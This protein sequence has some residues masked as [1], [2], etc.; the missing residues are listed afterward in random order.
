MHHILQATG[1]REPTLERSGTKNHMEDTVSILQTTLPVAIS[2]GDL[3][4]IRAQ[5][6]KFRQ[7]AEFRNLVLRI[8]V[9]F[10]WEVFEW[11]R[12]EAGA[13]GRRPSGEHYSRSSWSFRQ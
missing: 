6:R 12:P 7:H 9:W 5:S 2:H 13:A 4:E 10:L 8:P 11:S 3:V 1:N